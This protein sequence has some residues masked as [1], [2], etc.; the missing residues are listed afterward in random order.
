MKSISG[1]LLT[2]F[3]L[4]CTTLAVLWKLTRVDGTI[5]GFTTHDQN[6]VYAGVTYVADTGMT[7]TATASKSDMSVDNLE[8]T[9]FL[10]SDSIQEADIRA[11]LYD[12]ATIEIR[13]VNWADLTMGDLKIRSGTV[14]QIKMMNGVF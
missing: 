12:Y 14:G 10:D 6:I 4:D 7:N 8:V 5:M 13:I 1:P 9:A 11:G 3:G 2:H